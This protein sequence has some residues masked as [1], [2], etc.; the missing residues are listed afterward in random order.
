MIQNLF[1][2]NQ[3]IYIALFSAEASD[4][5]LN[6]GS[7]MSG[8]DHEE[9]LDTAP[10]TNSNRTVKQCKSN[11]ISGF[12]SLVSVLRLSWSG[13]GGEKMHLNQSL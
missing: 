6:D 12:I 8:Y 1:K 9:V 11:T 2:C 10:F 7:M 13:L 5:S 3:C 4:F